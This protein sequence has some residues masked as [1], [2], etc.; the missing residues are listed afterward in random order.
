M[1]PCR[2]LI[3]GAS[4]TGTS[5]LGRALAQAW[6][7]PWHDTDDY[8]WEPTDPPFRLKRA[9]EERLALM[10]AVFLPRR[11]WVISGSMMGWGDP[12]IPR[13][14]RVVLLRLDPAIRLERLRA[15]EATRA[16]AE[17]LQ[18]GGANHDAYLAFMN[19]A[20]GYDDPDFT[21]RSLKRHLAWLDTLPCP[22][23]TL[24]SAEPVERLVARLSRGLAAPSAAGDTSAN[25]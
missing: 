3:T 22:T 4:G 19:W 16:D 23:L 13:L 20:A 12:L 8:Y 14:D 24:D 15:R 18:P 6:S 1:T 10:E 25:R 5:T 9:P 17:T 7:V 21:G 2:L 11:A